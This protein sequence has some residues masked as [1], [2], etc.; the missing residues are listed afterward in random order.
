MPSSDNESASSAPTADTESSTSNYTDMDPV[1]ARPKLVQPPSQSTIPSGQPSRPP[2][3]THSDSSK[4]RAPVPPSAGRPGPYRKPLPQVEFKSVSI[5]STGVPKTSIPVNELAKEPTARK[6]SAVQKLTQNMKELGVA[7]TTS[8]IGGSGSEKVGEDLT[9]IP[10]AKK[11]KKLKGELASGKTSTST[12]KSKGKKRT[13]SDLEVGPGDD[14]EEAGRKHGPNTAV[15]EACDECKK[16]NLVCAVELGGS[17]A[18]DRCKAMKRGCMVG[19][20]K[21]QVRATKFD[22]AV[23]MSRVFA[24]LSHLTKCMKIDIELG[25][26]HAIVK[27]SSLDVKKRLSRLEQRFTEMDK[28]MDNLTE[29]SQQILGFL[30]TLPSSP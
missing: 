28:K 19:G 9:V 12:S 30:H 15:M 27:D 22:E 13:R 6:A 20:Q 29:L 18:C 25:E 24:L 7:P 16:S 14:D 4:N 2:P 17:K 23:S 10:P 3:P 26:V 5:S 1:L 11:L 8:K 21:R